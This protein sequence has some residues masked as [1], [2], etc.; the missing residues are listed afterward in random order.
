MGGRKDLSKEPN[1]REDQSLFLNDEEDE[2]E[3]PMD[4]VDPEI[5]RI[6]E[7]ERLADLEDESRRNYTRRYIDTH[8]PRDSQIRSDEDEMKVLFEW[9]LSTVNLTIEEDGRGFQG[10]VDYSTIA[11]AQTNRSF[12]QEMKDYFEMAV[13]AIDTD[14]RERGASRRKRKRSEDLV[15]ENS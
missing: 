14:R 11:E 10:A 2:E 7:M 6:R 3:I 1:D 8:L 15:E 13:L 9:M 4:E 12:L 5:L